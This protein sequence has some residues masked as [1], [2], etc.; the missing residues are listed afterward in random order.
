[1]AIDLTRLPKPEVVKLLDAQTI[2]AEN[3]ALFAEQMP[4]HDLKIG[5]PVYNTLAMMAAREVTIRQ[6]F[7]DYSLENMLA[8]SAGTNLDNLAGLSGSLRANAE[9]DDALR[10]R[11]Q[12]APEGYSTAGPFDGYIKLVLDAAPDEIKSVQPVSPTPNTVDL[13]IL[14]A[15]GDGTAS[16]EL[17]AKV[18][19]AANNKFERPIGDL[20]TAKT[21]II[22]T[23][24]LDAELHFD[25]GPSAEAARLAA[26]QQ[27]TEYITENH[28][29]GRNI[30]RAG[31]IAALNVSGIW[32]VD[33]IA[34]A[35]SITCAENE[36]AFCTLMNVRL[37]NNA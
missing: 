29:L 24:T 1:M 20:V 13:Y 30:T 36:A 2:L 16:V 33:L 31:L 14:S 35:A 26:E 25:E 8:Y 27:V 9:Q 37:A 11:A 22:K 12:L 18:Y 3:L 34:P 6:E 7:N 21:A 17:L 5:D 32:D 19:A 28:K 15:E 23:Y 10:I 4:M